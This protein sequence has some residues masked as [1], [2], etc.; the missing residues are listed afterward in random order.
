MSQINSR[1]KFLEGFLG[2][3]PEE[4]ISHAKANEVNLWITVTTCI[5][6]VLEIILY[7]LYNRMVYNKHID[8]YELQLHL[9]IHPWLPILNGVTQEEDMAGEDR[10]EEIELEE[11]KP[12]ENQEEE[13]K[14]EGN[15]AEEPQAEEHQAEENSEEIELEENKAEGNKAEENRAEENKAKGEG[16]MAKEIKKGDPRK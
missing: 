1:H 7:F 4:D 6:C 12:E 3:K 14:A 15:Q 9:Q 5:C 2:T 10:G 13:D 11:N 8:I 16:D